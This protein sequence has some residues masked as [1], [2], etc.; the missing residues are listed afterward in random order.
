VARTKIQVI[1]G[2]GAKPRTIVVDPEATVG[3]TLGSDVY[4][5][6]AVASP[7]AVRTWLGLGAPGANTDIRNGYGILISGTS[8]KTVSVNRAADFAWQGQHQWERP[9]WAPNGTAAL[10][11]LTFGSDLNTGIY[12]VGADNLGVST[13]GALRWDVTAARTY[14]SI[15][16]VIE[17]ALADSSKQQFINLL[18]NNTG[19]SDNAT[20]EISARV[21]AAGLNQGWQFGI[22]DALPSYP[23]SP[24]DAAGT[25]F[26]WVN[27]TTVVNQPDLVFFSHN[28]SAAGTEI[29]RHRYNLA[30]MLFASGSAGAPTI[31]FSAALTSGFF[32]DT[33]GGTGVSL[34]VGGVARVRTESGQ[35]LV[36]V[37]TRALDGSAGAP[38]YSFNSD[39]DNGFYYIGTNSFGVSVG[40]TLRLTYSTTAFT[41]TLPWLAPAGNAGAP[42]HSF[43]GD[44]D[45]GI[46]SQAAN[47]LG[48]AAGGAE[49]ARIDLSAVAGNT[50][51]LVYDVDN[52]TLERVTVGAADS[53]GTGFKVLRIPN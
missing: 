24:P 30:Q 5:N 43:S 28:N 35:M 53:G 41:A 7:T 34:S 20:L 17:M 18:S 44:P 25:G 36:A 50:R 32:W 1:G 15:T 47:A 33:A 37:P 29:Y 13:G 52:A 8:P 48:L 26:R 49:G 3:A 23:L 22:W 31:G 2:P 16:Q 6:G 46:F 27:A 12:R 4:L 19:L 39:N 40:G 45:T 14:Q 10:P 51:L 21:G 42:S 9:L 38:A 11:A